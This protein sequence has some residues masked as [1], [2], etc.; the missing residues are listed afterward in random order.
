MI[1]HGPGKIGELELGA[2]QV[3]MREDDAGK[4]GHAG[5]IPGDVE[6]LQI[7]RFVTSRTVQL[8]GGE[9]RGTAKD[10]GGVFDD[11]VGKVRPIDCRRSV[12]GLESRSGEVRSHKNRTAQDSPGKVGICESR[13]GEIR[14]GEGC[15]LKPGVGSLDVVE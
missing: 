10:E 14:V 6:T 5:N 9:A 4:V 15:V 2:R 1:E 3:L 13:A 11:R 12:V 7:P 8:R